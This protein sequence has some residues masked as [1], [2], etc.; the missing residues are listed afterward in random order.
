VN[1]LVGRMQCRK[2]QTELDMGQLSQLLHLNP[3]HP[4]LVKRSR[5][6]TRWDR[7]VA[8]RRRFRKAQP[9]SEPRVSAGVT[10]ARR[11]LF[12]DGM[13]YG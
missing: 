11:S 8:K 3:T 10:A 2:W 13:L 5:A 4:A 9:R 6:A 12:V 1:H 7:C